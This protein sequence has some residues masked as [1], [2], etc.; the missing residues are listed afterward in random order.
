M[1][2]FF[3]TILGSLGAVTTVPSTAT[4]VSI[5]DLNLVFDGNSLTAGVGATGAQDYPNY[6][7]NDLANKFNSKTFASF[8]VGGQTTQSMISDATTQ[9]YSKYQSGKQ[10]V[11]IAWEDANSFNA[12]RTAQENYDDFKTYFQGAKNA[13]FEHCILITGMYYRKSP[14]DTYRN[15]NGAI[16]PVSRIQNIT[17]Y[18]DLVYGSDINLVPWDYT[19]DLRNAPVVGGAIGQQKDSNWSD[20]VHLTDSGYRLI[21]N[22]VT[23]KI[24]EIFNII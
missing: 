24:K 16:M 9:I 6:V 2:I 12:G 20:A 14:D 17:D 15:I 23:A 1:N 18:S 4:A 8:G 21:A 7:N 11:L 22:V 3:N 13:G 19:I 10:N 5:E